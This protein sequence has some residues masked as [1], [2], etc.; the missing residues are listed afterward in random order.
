ML[1]DFNDKMDQICVMFGLTIKESD[2]RIVPVAGVDQLLSFD[3]KV[4]CLSEYF[5]AKHQQVFASSS[6]AK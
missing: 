3:T 6:A 5:N 1:S 2:L 4:N